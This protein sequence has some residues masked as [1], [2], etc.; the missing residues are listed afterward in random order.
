MNVFETIVKN[1]LSQSI[2]LFL[3]SQE[4]DLTVEELLTNYNI[5]FEN[6]INNEKVEKVEEK[7]KS[8]KEIEEKIIES[9]EH[10]EGKCKYKFTKGFVSGLYCNRCVT[11]ESNDKSYCSKHYKQMQNLSDVP[12]C[13]FVSEKNIKCTNTSS[14]TFKDKKLCGLHHYT[15]TVLRKK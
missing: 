13:E 4:H 1:T 9:K 10:I 2:L 8:K 14:Y 5:Y 12:K 6:F 3:E 15:E 11:D 7:G